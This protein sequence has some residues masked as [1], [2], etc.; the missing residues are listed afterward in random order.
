MRGHL[1]GDFV[2]RYR[3][4][5]AA[6]E[7]DEWNGDGVVAREHD[8]IFG[9]FM[10]HGCHLRDIAGGFFDAD[11]V[12]DLREARSVAGSTLTPVRPCTL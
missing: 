9:D 1:G 6:A 10:D 5:A 3:D 7:R 4:D 2:G 8:E 11:D 12:V